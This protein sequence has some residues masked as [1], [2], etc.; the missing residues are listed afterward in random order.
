MVKIGLQ[1]SAILEN[2]SAFQSGDDFRWYL[3]IK[4][5]S[6]GEISRTWQYICANESTDTKGGR[7]SANMVQKC[8]M[9]GRENHMDI[10][11]DKI[12]SYTN[13]DSGSFVTIISFE[14]RG[15]E[16]VEFDFRNGW[17]VNSSCSNTVFSDVDLS[18]KEW[19]DYDDTGN[20]SVSITELQSNFVKL[21]K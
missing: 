5:S 8:K 18:E 20:E 3:K 14:C 2:V 6:C 13:D 12:K 21:K 15:I 10:I 4:C 16:P 1:I 19:Y 17:K 7:G 9:C 11:K